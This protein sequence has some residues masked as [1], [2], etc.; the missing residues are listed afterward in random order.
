MKTDSLKVKSEKYGI[1]HYYAQCNECVWDCGMD[2]N[3][4]KR[5]ENVRRKIKKHVT[6]TGHTVTL[7]SGSSTDYYLRV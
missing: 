5:T 6:R 4:K 3:H 2:I 7:E 1:V